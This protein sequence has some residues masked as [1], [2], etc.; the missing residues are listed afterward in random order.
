MKSLSTSSATWLT[1]YLNGAGAL[2]YSGAIHAQATPDATLEVGSATELKSKTAREPAPP[3][4]TIEI[5]GKTVVPEASVGIWGSRPILDTPFT[6]NRYDS[7]LIEDQQAVSANQ[8]IRNDPALTNVSTPGGFSGFNLSF[9]GFPSGAD[10]IS[11]FGM[12]PGGMFS[13]SLG[14]LYSVERLDVVKGPSSAL[15]GFSPNAAVGGSVT[16]VPKLPLAQNRVTLA[17]GVRERGIVSGHADVS[18]RF[19]ETYSVR[20]NLAQESGETFYSGRDQRDVEA[21]AVS[22][23]LSNSAQLDVGFDS[24]DV[25][26]EGYQNGFILGPNVSVPKA[27]NPSKNHF[28]K[29]T[30][31][32]QGWNY[33]YSN[34]NWVL[35][36][37]WTLRMQGLYGIR[38]GEV[39]SSGTGFIRNNEGDMTLRPSYRPR[40]TDYNPFWGGNVFVDANFHTGSW[41]HKVTLAYLANGFDFKGGVTTPIAPIATNLFRPV[42]VDKPISHVI[43]KGKSSSVDANTQALTDQIDI[44]DHTSVLVGVKNSTLRSEA[45]DIQTGIRTL[46]QND[47]NTSPL[48]AITHAWDEKT[49][50]YA[51]FAQGFERGGI[52]PA[53]AANADRLMPNV[54]NQQVEIGLKSELGSNLLV[55]ASLF[56]IERGLEYIDAVTNF[57]VQDGLQRNRGLEVSANGNVTRDIGL[58]GGFLVLDPKIVR[59]GVVNDKAAPGVPTYTLPLYASYQIAPALGLS[60]G[61]NHFGKQYIDVENTRSLDPWTRWDAG[62]KHSTV[63]SDHTL[64][65]GV[66]VEN[67]GNQ[68]YWASASGGQLVLGSPEIWKL[69]VR[70]EL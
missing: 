43:A 34:L 48:A 37:T 61:V 32:K 9:R 49:R 20:V 54:G 27:P 18:H 1:L 38:T 46:K 21:L 28:Q 51:S 19:N 36:S 14:Q 66:Q 67:I 63:I 23:K 13:G 41:R 69:S 12:G 15:G 70:T 47:S 62:L 22:V 58:T 16:I 52:A 35:D 59:N 4:E 17:A 65:I 3:I 2:L 11:F 24:A 7:K 42:Y 60:L 44:T 57:Y 6:L 50:L 39:F 5:E 45:F 10:S 53:T 56:Q 26:S 55:S 25:K 64:T 8:V 40:G 29:W 68:A 30:Y 33:G 31:L